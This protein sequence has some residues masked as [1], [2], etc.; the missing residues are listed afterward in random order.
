MSKINNCVLDKYDAEPFEQQQ[1]G[2]AGAE[3]LKHVVQKTKCGV[4]KKSTKISKTEIL[5]RVSTY[6]HFT[7]KNFTEDTSW[8]PSTVQQNIQIWRAFTKITAHSIG[9]LPI[10]PTRNVPRSSTAQPKIFLEL[11]YVTPT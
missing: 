10:D 11:N 2:T 4:Q 8:N 6:M 5:S 9:A 3:G 1:F 7:A